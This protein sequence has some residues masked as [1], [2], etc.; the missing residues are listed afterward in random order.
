MQVR[1]DATDQLR[2]PTPHQVIPLQHIFV[3]HEKLVTPSM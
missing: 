2:L 1:K 3:I